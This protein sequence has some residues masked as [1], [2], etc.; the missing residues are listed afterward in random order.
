MNIITSTLRTIGKATYHGQQAVKSTKKVVTTIPSFKQ[1]IKRIT[2]DISSG[3]SIAMIKDPKSQ[4][5]KELAS[6]IE[7]IATHPQQELALP[8]GDIK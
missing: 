3:Y 5:R 2:S 8:L 1:G 4:W 6:D 7:E